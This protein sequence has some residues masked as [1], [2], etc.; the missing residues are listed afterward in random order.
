MGANYHGMQAKVRAMGKRLL[1]P[2]DYDALLSKSTVREI[3]AYLKEHTGYSGA[4]SRLE[5]TTVHRGDLEKAVQWTFYDEVMKILRFSSAQ[6]KRFFRLY[7]LR[8]ETELLKR[9]LRGYVSGERVQEMHVPEGYRRYLQIQPDSLLHAADLSAVIEQMRGTDYYRL[10]QRFRGG[11][12]LFGM[13]MTLDDF[14]FKRAWNTV[15]KE[16]SGRNRELIED[17]L[18]SEI[19]LLNIIWIARCKRFYKMPGERIPAYLI[20]ISHKLSKEKLTA[21]TAAPD[22]EGVFDRLKGTCY[23]GIFTDGVPWEMAMQVYLLKKH[24]QHYRQEPLSIGCPI[25]FLHLKENEISNIVKMIERARYYAQ[26]EL[27]LVR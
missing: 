5:E 11:N 2:E 3:A 18:G 27:L 17:T 4:L 8:H 23:D 20:P 13:E 10:L 14:Y 22:A 25:G 16:L 26:Q 15:Q 12:D 21:L 6:D 9:V 19:D 24:R 7:I 1:S